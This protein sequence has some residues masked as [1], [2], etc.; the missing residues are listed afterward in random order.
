[1]A[2]SIIF[3]LVSLGLLLFS[4]LPYYYWQRRFPLPFGW[5]TRPLVFIGSAFACNLLLALGGYPVGLFVLAYLGLLLLNGSLIISRLAALPLP[6]AAQIA[7][8]LHL[9]LR[10]YVAS[11]V[12]LLAHFT[13]LALN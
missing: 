3:T 5:L 2:A 11:I 7:L 8:G 1:M 13:R 10:Y 4:A 9:L 6:L 12:L